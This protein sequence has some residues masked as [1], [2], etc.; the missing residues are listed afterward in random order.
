MTIRNLGRSA[1]LAA[2]V[3]LLLAPAAGHADQHSHAKH[4]VLI[5][6]DGLHQSDLDWYVSTHGGS[7]LAR[8]VHDGANYT[9][10]RTPFPS[11][12]FPG[13][14]G[15]VTG[16]NPKSAGIYYDDSWNRKL[17]PPGTTD[18]QHTAP[19]VEVTYFEALDKNPLAIDAGYGVGDISTSVAI[20]KNIYKL[21]GQAR[22]LIDATQLPIDPATCK[23]VYPHSYLRVNTVFEVAKAHGLHTAW[24]DKHAAY[25]LV[26]GPSGAGVDDLF[27]PEINSTIPADLVGDGK[28]DD[29]FTKN[30]LNTQFYDSLKVGAVINWANGH[31]H[32]GNGTPGVPAI[33]GMNF[34]TVSTAQKLNFSHFAG[35]QGV[36]GLG[37]YTSGGSL[38]G[39]VLQGALD[40][41]DASMQK[42]V[43]AVD[44]KDT[45]VILSAKHGQSPV[46]RS[47][48]RL[49]D[50][51]EVTG[52]LDDA[53]NTQMKTKTGL[54]A[55]AIDDDGM[56]LWLKDRSNTATDFAKNF[57]WNYQ[58]KTV[59][60]S[61]P[62]GGF[63]DYS[64]TVQ[65]SG[66]RKIHAGEAAADFIGVSPTD[67]RVPD[68]IGIA[69]VGTVYSDPTKIKK[70]AE[71]GGN[72]AQDRHVP[73]VVWG[74]GVEREWSHDR[75]ET[76]QI[77]PTILKLLGLSPDELKA[78]RIEDTDVLPGLD[79]ERR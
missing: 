46:D 78:V 5:S 53:W 7:T 48:L 38:P 45:V 43:S 62:D 49:I 18:C 9:N 11:D 20:K 33:Y 12:S 32:A 34:Q 74:A 35:D 21:S 6:V 13:L 69:T 24:S 30:N 16:G 10:A 44:P 59:G 8:L 37:G 41:I 17:L 79:L 64:G 28:K 66:L 2:A 31:D 68:V 63:K 70:I 40:F 29:D 50:D 75:V 39:A 51:G 15:Q 57:L 61:N 19:G 36:K 1:A 25:D 56:L 27:A 72:A 26:N 42:I 54:V 71:H 22:D 52:A 14:T 58:P 67:E 55:F 47:L 4:V 77:A 60:G 76:T 3:A 73:I 23:G 65:H